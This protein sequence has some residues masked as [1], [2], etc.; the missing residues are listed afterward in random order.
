MN[1][2]R[3]LFKFFIIP[4]VSFLIL[5]LTFLFKGLDSEKLPQYPS[6]GF[7]AKNYNKYLGAEITVTGK[8]EPCP[9]LSQ[10]VKGTQSESNICFLSDPT[11][12]ED[13]V[14][15]KMKTKVNENDLLSFGIYKVKGVVESSS[16][17]WYGAQIA[18]NAV[19]RVNN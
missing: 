1:F 8:F 16:D 17:Y 4:A 5:S 18:V 3:K 12:S 9:A 2:N 7:L 15:I 13:K 14:K 19:K 6:I 10:V 11:N